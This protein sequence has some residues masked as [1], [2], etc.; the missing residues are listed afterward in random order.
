[1][2]NITLQDLITEQRNRISKL[3]FHSDEFFSYYDY[4]D[5]NIYY[6]WLAKTNR[7]L[8][9]NFPEDKHI[10][11]FEQIGKKSICPQ[12]QQQLLAI[13]EAFARLPITISR[14]KDSEFNKQETVHIT[15]NITNSNNQSQ[16]QD[17]A[18]FINIF[19]DAIKDDLT[20]RQIKE[21]KTVVAEADN[22]LEKARLNIVEKLKSFGANVASNI[23]ANLLTNPNIWR[24]L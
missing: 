12:Q 17:Q 11:E 1:M 23:V 8:E 3:S 6:N 22:N 24:G 21:L 18:L 7:F 4:E 15:T 14:T 13:L 16:S 10:E 2:D 19:L 5:M 9:I 20:G